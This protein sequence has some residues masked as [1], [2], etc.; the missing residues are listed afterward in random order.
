M[1]KEKRKKKL[2]IISEKHPS[3]FKQDFFHHF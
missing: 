3:L 1:S 2:V